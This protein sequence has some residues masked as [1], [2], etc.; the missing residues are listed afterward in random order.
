MKGIANSSYRSFVRSAR[1]HFALCLV[2]DIQCFF[3][4]SFIFA[5]IARTIF[6]EMLSLDGVFTH[7]GIHPNLSTTDS[8]KWSLFPE[9][10]RPQGPGIFE[11]SATT[12]RLSSFRRIQI[13]VH[14]CLSTGSKH[15]S[16]G[17]SS[18]WKLYTLWVP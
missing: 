4:I 5:Q 3:S 6:L 17:D 1:E 12:N 18:H 8:V 7:L 2:S 14:R 16:C 11:A 10:R 15:L 13:Q 9:T